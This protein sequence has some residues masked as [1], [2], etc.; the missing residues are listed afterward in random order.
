ME[1]ALEKSRKMEDQ[2]RHKVFVSNLLNPQGKGGEDL[3]LLYRSIKDALKSHNGVEFAAVKNTAD[4]W[5]RDYM[6]IQ[7]DRDTFVTYKYRPDYLWSPER[8]KYITTRFSLRQTFWRIV[9]KRWIFRFIARGLS[10]WSVI[11]LLTEAMWWC[12]ATELF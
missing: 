3:R 12:V 9:K 8:R 1:A 11:L 4:I 6:P 10:S 5:M 7:I 2:I